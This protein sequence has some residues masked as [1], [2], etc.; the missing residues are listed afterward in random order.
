MHILIN[1]AR[2]RLKANSL[3]QE[4]VRVKCNPEDCWI[5]LSGTDN[6]GRKCSVSITEPEF[7]KIRKKIFAYYGIKAPDLKAIEAR[8]DA[9]IR[10]EGL[11]RITSKNKG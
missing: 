3:L 10:A 6:E 2:G 8:R 4:T 1:T 9:E 11:R 7:A 5:E